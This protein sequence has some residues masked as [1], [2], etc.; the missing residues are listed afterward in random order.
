V[1]PLPQKAPPKGRA[2]TPGQSVVCYADDV[3]LGGGVIKA[4]DA[5]LGGLQASPVG[6]G[7]SRDLVVGQSKSSRGEPAPTKAPPKGQ[8]RVSGRLV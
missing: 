8:R 1:N 7:L 5:Y 3:C 6:A 4:S 2:I